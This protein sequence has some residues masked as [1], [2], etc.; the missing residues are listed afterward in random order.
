MATDRAGKRGRPGRTALVVLGSVAVASLSA[1]TFRTAYLHWGAATFEA[2]EQ[3]PGDDLIADPGLVSTRAI[4]IEAPPEQVWPWVAQLGQG[5]GGFYSHD[6]LENLF[7]CDVH[8]ATSVVSQWQDPQAGDE[9]RLH[10]RVVLRVAS[11]DPG[12]SM[13]IEGRG[14]PG[15]PAPPYD[16]TWAFVVQ[17]H[18]HGA[19]R[20]LVRERYGYTKPWSAAVVEPLAAVSALMSRRML[21]GIR[22]RAESR[23]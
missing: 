3:L 20:L 19:T 14:Q 17:P 8:S 21:L 15:E 22:E 9:F 16:F 2:T 23:A 12:E 4:T 5:R 11:V 6:R 13:V 18:P 7:G 10:P 1:T